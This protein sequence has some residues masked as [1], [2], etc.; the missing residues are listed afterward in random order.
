[1]LLAVNGGF[2]YNTW[3]N[4]A[5]N[6]T[7]NATVSEGEATLAFTGT[8]GSEACDGDYIK[9]KTIKVH[10]ENIDCMVKT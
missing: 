1:M 7:G 8:D 4:E 10:G 6:A 2:E 9:T 3:M 5:R